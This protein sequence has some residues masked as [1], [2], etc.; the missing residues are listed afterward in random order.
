MENVM[1][2]KPQTTPPCRK[3]PYGGLRHSYRELRGPDGLIPARWVKINQCDY[4]GHKKGEK[5]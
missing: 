1:S 2:D 3:N 4:C 5:S